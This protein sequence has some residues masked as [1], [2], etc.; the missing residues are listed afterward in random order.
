[1]LGDGDRSWAYLVQ[2][3]LP[4]GLVGIVLAGLAS[5]ILGT[6]AAVVNSSSTIFT[7]DIYKP[8]LRKN[9]ADKELFLTGRISSTLFFVLGVCTALLYASIGGS[10]FVMI[11]TAFSYMAAPIAAVFLVGILWKG[12]TPK[13]ATIALIVGFLS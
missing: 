8:L 1:E 2:A 11:Q 7:Y 3:M 13:A 4:S 5:S 12:A 6:L 10:I 9:A